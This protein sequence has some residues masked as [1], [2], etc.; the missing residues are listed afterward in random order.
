MPLLTE[1]EYL[2]RYYN[3]LTGRMSYVSY[4]KPYSRANK[5]ER[6]AKKNAIYREQVAT[7]KKRNNAL[8]RNRTIMH[9]NMAKAN[10]P[11]YNDPNWLAKHN[12]AKWYNEVLPKAQALRNKILRRRALAIIRRYWYQPPVTG[13]GYQRQ[14]KNV[15]SRWK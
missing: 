6:E 8:L 1:A 3:Y 5:I 4:G 12:L 15:S 10:P 14:L 2:Q 7:R 13:R 11:R 9:H